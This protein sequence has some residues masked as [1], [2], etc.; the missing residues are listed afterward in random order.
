MCQFS[1]AG[2]PDEELHKTENKQEML[3]C[4]CPPSPKKSSQCPQAA[5]FVKGIFSLEWKF[6]KCFVVLVM[7]IKVIFVSQDRNGEGCPALHNYLS[8]KRE[9]IKMGN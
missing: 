1:I 5:V 3:L 6:R 2:E 4:P 9:D 8:Q 7:V